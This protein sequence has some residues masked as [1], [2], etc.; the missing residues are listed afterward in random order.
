MGYV[1]TTLGLGV[2]FKEDEWNDKFLPKLIKHIEEKTGESYSSD[3]EDEMYDLIYNLKEWYGGT[4]NIV[5]NYGYYH[6]EC[7]ISFIIDS[8][9]SDIRSGQDFNA[10]FDQNDINGIDISEEILK[11]LGIGKKGLRLQVMVYNY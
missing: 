8:D 6:S 3:D 5:W 9:D 7:T 1:K 4:Y 10:Q 2:S 11:I